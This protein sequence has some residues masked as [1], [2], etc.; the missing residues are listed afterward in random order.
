MSAHHRTYLVRLDPG[1]LDDSA[2]PRRI[3]VEF[4]DWLETTDAELVQLCGA[5]RVVISCSPDIAEQIR[6]LEYVLDV[7]P[8][9]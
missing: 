9:A 1:I 8:H 4:F 3:R 2:T 5:D 7:E 6:N